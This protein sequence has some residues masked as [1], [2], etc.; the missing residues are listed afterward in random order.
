MGKLPKIAQEELDTFKSLK[1]VKVVFDVGA[2]MTMDTSAVPSII[3]YLQINP[4]AE[5][6]LFEPHPVWFDELKEAVGDKKN[7][8]LN[9]FGLGDVDGEFKYNDGLQAF[10]GGEIKE[11]AGNKVLP[12]KTLDWYVKKNKIK[13][14]DFLK[15]DTEGYDYKVL[16]GGAETLKMTRYI[17]YELWDNKEQFEKL[18]SKDFLLSEPLNRNI[19]ATRI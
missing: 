18:L 13:E 12:V 16:L 17:Q 14:I 8:H 4:D 5:Y 3:Y 2:R 7:V 6:H 11:M 10:V 19:L 15:I 9:N 1:K